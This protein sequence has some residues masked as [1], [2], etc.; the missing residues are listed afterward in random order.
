[1]KSTLPPMLNT[2]VKAARRA[3]AIINRAAQDLDLIPVQRKA[4]NDFVS[5]VDRAAEQAIIEVLLKAYPNHEILAEE[6]GSTGRSEFVWIIDPLDGTTN[7]LHGFPHY[8]VSIALSHG[9][10]LK[11]AVVFDPTKNDLFTASRGNGACLSDRRIRV[12]NRDKL[13]DALLGT[14]FPF[15]ELASLDTY[16]AIFT[17]LMQKTVGLRRPGSAA[18]DLAYVACGRYDGFWEMGLSPWDIAGG[19]LLI[20]EA[21]GLVSDFEGNDQ[22]LK[23]GNVLAGN[24]KILSQMMQVV[25]AHWKRAPAR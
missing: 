22:F 18:L 4:P 1:M 21:G 25:Q 23:S 6:S 13:A 12:S 3:G 15:R 19:A 5:E 24:P 2:A 10:K 14:G 20:M 7:F 11:Q 9:G 17:E 16:V 8:A